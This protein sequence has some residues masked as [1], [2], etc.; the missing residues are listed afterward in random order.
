MAPTVTAEATRA[1][2]VVDASTLELPA[3]SVKCTPDEIAEA[4]ALSRAVETPPP[5]DM[6]ATEGRPDDA[7]ALLTKLTPLITSALVPDPAS[8]RVEVEKQWLREY[9]TGIPQNFDGNDGSAGC[10]A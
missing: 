7:A 8:L 9:L 5:K 10:R 6:F 4:T 2:E 3:A 1:G